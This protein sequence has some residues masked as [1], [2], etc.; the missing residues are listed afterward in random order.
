MQDVLGFTAFQAGLGF[1]PMTAVNFT[2]ATALPRIARRLGEAPTLV[3]GV[4]L[5]LAGMGWLA[6]VHATST[7]LT[8]VALP[9]VLIGAGQGLAFAPLTSFGMAGVRAEDAGAASGL[10]NT[11]HQL[12][13]A[14]GLAVLVAT[15]ADAVDL[16]PRGH[17]ADLGHRPLGAVPGRC[18]RN[19]PSRAATPPHPRPP[20]RAEPWHQLT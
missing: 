14:T 10:V 2:V 4:A 15:S 18:A 12:G 6:Q 9:M 11:A 16:T 20:P 1:L 5:T 8:A 7:Y 19:R 13:M 3:A 17:R